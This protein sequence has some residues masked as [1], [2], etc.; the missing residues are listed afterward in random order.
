M[1]RKC[2][3]HRLLTGPLHLK[4]GARNTDIYNIIKVKQPALFL[5][6][7]IAEL[8]TNQKTTAQYKTPTTN[9][10][11]NKQ[12]VQHPH[13][14]SEI[15]RYFIINE[16]DLLEQICYYN[17]IYCDKCEKVRHKALAASE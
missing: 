13:I 12:S 11:N 7:M 6:K 14:I 8:E 1:T 16:S 4:E 9:R 10:N 3:K 17:F 5:V 2:H 15:L